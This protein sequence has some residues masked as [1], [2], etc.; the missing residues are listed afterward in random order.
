MVDAAEAGGW[1]HRR[2]DGVTTAS[3]RIARVVGCC[4]G[5]GGEAPGQGLD[6]PISPLRTRISDKTVERHRANILEGL[7]LRDRVNAGSDRNSAERRPDG[8]HRSRCTQD[9]IGD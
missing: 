7:R 5:E 3:R 1:T 6:S 8:R 4:R 2:M 9:P